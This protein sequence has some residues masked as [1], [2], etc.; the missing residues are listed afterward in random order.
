MR[1]TRPQR[2]VLDRLRKGVPPSR[3]EAM[4]RQLP[5]I[6]GGPI[7]LRKL[8]EVGRTVALLSTCLTLL[9]MVAGLAGCRHHSTPS[10]QAHTVASFERRLRD[11]LVEARVGE[12]SLEAYLTDLDVVGC[13]ELEE[14][15]LVTA[16]AG[17]RRLH[18]VTYERTS[19][20]GRLI[21]WDVWRRRLMPFSADGRALVET[22]LDQPALGRADFFCDDDLPVAWRNLEPGDFRH[23]AAAFFDA[24]IEVRRETLLRD[25]ADAASAVV[26]LE[27][28]RSRIERR[29]EAQFGAGED[30]VLATLRIDLDDLWERKVDPYDVGRPVL[31]VR[32]APVPDPRETLQASQP[33]M[34]ATYSDHADA[35]SRGGVKYAPGWVPPQAG[36]IGGPIPDPDDVARRNAVVRSWKRSRRVILTEARE[37]ARKAAEL[38]EALAS[39]PPGERAALLRQI[40]RLANGVDHLSADL[41]RQRDYVATYTSGRAGTDRLVVRAKRKE[42]KR[43]RR[44]RRVVETAQDEVQEVIDRVQEGSLAQAAGSG[45]DGGGGSGVGGDLS[46]GTAVPRVPSPDGIPGDA[47]STEVPSAGTALTYE[48]PCPPPDPGWSGDVVTELQQHYPMLDETDARIFLSLL[49]RVRPGSRD[50]VEAVVLEHL[51]QGVDLRL[52]AGHADELS[53]QYDPALADDEQEAIVFYVWLGE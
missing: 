29:F 22:Y 18:R 7:G 13:L 41:S 4:V 10:Y 1:A 8:A 27:E 12:Q 49:Q 16:L 9:P 50:A 15:Q 33:G 37:L 30:G 26:I 6:P 44:K 46:T 34:P 2:V 38:E 52:R 36:G 14:E 25:G 47:S 45:G 31:L 3:V 43:I 23:R 42:L 32:Q 28:L 20:P 19:G 51:R 53:E 5:N 17:L 35:A 11:H 40:H 24:E 39:V 48:G 21:V